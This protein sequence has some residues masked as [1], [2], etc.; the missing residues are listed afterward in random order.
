MS[1][2]QSYSSDR[3]AAL[4]KIVLTTTAGL[5]AHP[6]FS[7]HQPIAEEEKLGIALVGLGRYSQLVLKSALGHCQRVKLTGIVTGSPEKAAEWSRSF[8]LPQEKI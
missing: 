4:K 6:L 1:T 2:N 7:A 5:F 8:D 3:R